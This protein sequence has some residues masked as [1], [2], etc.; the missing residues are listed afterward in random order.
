MKN[1]IL[2]LLLG[3][4]FFDLN[5]QFGFTV[6]NRFN[7]AT[8]WE[9]I[10]EDGN[11]TPNTPILG[12]GFSFGVD[13][14]FRLKNLR[15]EFLPEINYGKYNNFDA[16]TN[17]LNIDNEFISLF[18]N[19]NIYLFDLVSDCN[20]PTFSKQDDFLQKGF[21]IQLSP[22]YSFIRNSI[23]WEGSTNDISKGAF[24]I[25]GGI[26]LDIG[27]SD[28][29]TLTPLLGI[30]FYPSVTLDD[31]TTTSSQ[32]DEQLTLLNEDSSIAQTYFGLRLGIR[33]DEQKF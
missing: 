4:S 16:T 19:T 28:L 12:D 27:L 1:L 25:G 31:F 17:G 13:Y 9:L 30:R 14:W 20:C 11:G 33:L 3:L 5:A 23:S 22:G 8:N 7:D 32:L 10:V 24:S 26:G 6:S 18:F 2:I 15:I 29:V 21:F